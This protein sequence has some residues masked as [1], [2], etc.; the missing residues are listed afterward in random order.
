MRADLGCDT[1]STVCMDLAI[2]GSSMVQEYVNV[3]CYVALQEGMLL[4]QIALED[5][6]LC[7]Y[8]ARTSIKD[9]VLGF[10]LRFPSSLK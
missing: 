7:D 3:I 9:L 1:T 10:Q 2:F 4:L 5:I 8:A 6:S